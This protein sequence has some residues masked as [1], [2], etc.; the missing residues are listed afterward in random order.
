[1]DFSLLETMRLDGG[2][3]VRLDRHLTRLAASACHFEYA[4]DEA[5][6]RA[7]RRRGTQSRQ[8]GE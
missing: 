3:M 8:G 5:T 6:I 1:M 4:Y 7:A 2:S